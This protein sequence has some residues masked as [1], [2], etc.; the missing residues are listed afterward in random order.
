VNAVE[1]PEAVAVDRR[2]GGRR[3]WLSAAVGWSVIA[4]GVGGVLANRVDTRPAS[5]ARFVVGGALVHDLVVAPLVVLVGL[6]VARALPGPGR[7]RAAVQVAAIL[8]G[9]AALF[10]YPLV[11]GYGRALGN[12][13]SLPRN[14]GVG[15]AVVVGAVWLAALAVL[16]LA[17]AR[18]PRPPVPS[19]RLDGPPIEHRPPG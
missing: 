2:P 14:Y 1:R 9:V 7:A 12:P 10:A 15:L 3:F 8:S 18:R 13:T 16:V 4:F 11:R 6:L 17:P 19:A 5:L